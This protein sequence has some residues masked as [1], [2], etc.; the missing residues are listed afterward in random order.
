MA[1]N[2]FE[3]YGEDSDRFNKIKDLVVGRASSLTYSERA[4][5]LSEIEKILDYYRTEKVFYDVFCSETILRKGMG[6]S[7]TFISDIVSRIGAKESVKGEGTWFGLLT[8]ARNAFLLDEDEI[9]P[10]N[11][12]SLRASYNKL[13]YDERRNFR[14]MVKGFGG[15]VDQIYAQY[16]NL[17]KY[18]L[19]FQLKDEK[20]ADAIAK[21]IASGDL[22]YALK[23][24]KLKAYLKKMVESLGGTVNVDLKGDNADRAMRRKKYYDLL[25][26]NDAENE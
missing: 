11:I 1:D 17:E 7:E 16:T 2:F 23:D 14:R 10:Q 15:M 19:A 6:D 24:Q 25:G 5:I 22:E 4:E 9:V 26:V 18:L 3:I 8:A 12:N 20:K 13:A 21:L